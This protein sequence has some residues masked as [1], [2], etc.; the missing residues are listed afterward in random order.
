MGLGLDKG[1]TL[2]QRASAGKALA[3]L[4]QQ[5]AQLH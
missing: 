1:E 3:L 2:A 5:F 4:D